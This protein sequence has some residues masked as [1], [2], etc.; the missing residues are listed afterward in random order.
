MRTTSSNVFPTNHSAST[1]CRG[2]VCRPPSRQVF[3]WRQLRRRR[4][5]YKAHPLLPLS[6]FCS[7]ITF[8]PRLLLESNSQP[9]FAPEGAH[10]DGTMCR[11][12]ENKLL[13]EVRRNSEANHNTISTLRFAA[14]WFPQFFLRFCA[15]NKR[16]VK[17]K[18]SKEER[19]SNTFSTI[20]TLR[21]AALVNRNLEKP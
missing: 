19:L 8:P 16:I 17:L 4:F 3:L 2:S 1:L 12:E 14:A 18:S 7:S 9:T 13:G 10:E 21:F 20:P 15:P 11:C 6:Q 5:Y